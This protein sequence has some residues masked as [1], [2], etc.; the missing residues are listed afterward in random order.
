MK[1]GNNFKWERIEGGLEAVLVHAGCVT[2][3]HA[4]IATEA[5]ARMVLENSP[6]TACGI[7]GEPLR[8]TM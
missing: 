5:E 3:L 7:C 8:E 4:E 6:A 1:P 2:D